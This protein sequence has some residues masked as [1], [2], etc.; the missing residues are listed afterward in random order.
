MNQETPNQT[1]TPIVRPNAMTQ[2]PDA[3]PTPL[4]KFLPEDYRPNPST[5]CETCPNAIFFQALDG[6]M[7]CHCSAM[8]VISWQTGEKNPITEC[9]GREM[10]LLAKKA[11]AERQAERE[12]KK[13]TSAAEAQALWFERHNAK[14]TARQQREA[15]REAKAAAKA[16]SKTA[17]KAAE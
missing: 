16:A 8:S 6:L 12:A 9:D 11:K 7:K 1:A 5:S 4:I 14:E 3:L 17:T 10:A 2:F 13:A 15:E